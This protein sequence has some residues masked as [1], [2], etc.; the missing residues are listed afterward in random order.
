LASERHA[1]G[2]NHVARSQFAATRDRCLD[3][4]D[5]PNNSAFFLNRRP[6]FGANRTGHTAAQ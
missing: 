5:R 1:G 4:P 6:A 2:V 3:D